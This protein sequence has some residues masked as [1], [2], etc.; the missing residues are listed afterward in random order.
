MFAITGL[1]CYCEGHCPTTTQNGTCEVKQGGQC[2]SMVE[3]VYDETTG[4]MEAEYSFGCISADQGSSLL[5][6]LNMNINIHLI[7]IFRFE[8]MV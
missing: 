4:Q 2:F 1:S 7:L 3:E 6:V 5:Q 8:F